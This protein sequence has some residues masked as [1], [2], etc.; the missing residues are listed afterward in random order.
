MKSV[1]QKIG[2]DIWAYLAV[3]LAVIFVW[4]W[5][6]NV[7]TQIKTEE[8]VSVFIGTYSASFEKTKELNEVRPSYLKTVEVNA[9]TLNDGRFGTYLSVFGYETGDI[10]ILP[11]SKVTAESCAG[12]FAEISA[13]YQA[14]FA[15]YK[16]DGESL[17]F[18][19]EDKVYGIKVY[20]KDSRKSLIS[21]L[22]YVYE[23]K[24][25]E[26]FYLFFN[27]KSVHLSDLTDESKRSEMNGAID[28]AKRLLEL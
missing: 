26:N 14:V 18:Y 28:I 8:K 20:D 11:E 17:G 7:L 24:E 2:K 13:A 15:E 25:E 4:S 5:V 27:K 6:Y 19:G 21:C 22:N 1:L 3:I 16:V 9:Y 12:I 23:G 10:L